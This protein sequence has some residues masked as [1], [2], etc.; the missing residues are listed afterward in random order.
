MD[1]EVLV[2]ES[3]DHLFRHDIGQM[4]SVLT[5]IFGI[6]KLDLVEDALQVALA[7]A[8]NQW[9]F[10]GIPKNPKAWLI[11]V[12]KNHMLDRLRRDN[13]SVDFDGEIKQT[14]E[15][16]SRVD[17]SDKIYFEDE[18]FEDQLQMIFA[19]CHPSIP[20]DSQ[21]ALTLK[22]VGGFSVNEI[23]HAFLAKIDATAKMIT[24]AK[25]RLR[26]HRVRLEIPEPEKI[27][28][29]LNAVLKVLYLMFNE[30][31]MAST[32][33]K[34]TRI[35][36]CNEAIRLAKLLAAHSVTSLPKVNALTA[37]LLFQAS[38]LPA[39]NS[40]DGT[41]LILA[42]QDRTLWD[43]RKI[44]EGLK[45]FRASASGDDLSV[46]HLE[47]EIA[48]YH[49]LSKSFEATD[50]K[51]LVE[52]Y[53]E[54]LKR[55]PSPIVALNKTIAV[56]QAQGAK[57]ALAE[58]NLLSDKSLNTYYPFFITK[59]ELLRKTSNFPEALEAYERAF[60]LTNN[61]AIKKFVRAKITKLSTSALSIANVP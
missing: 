11:Q 41:V 33:E 34:L 56:S 30:G 35:D 36:L 50:W 40:D 59:G 13:K 39:R 22:T 32:G 7:K 26:E 12:A 37:L 61:E 48:S 20:V 60:Q 28:N 53:G 17:F 54:L 47:A 42:E 29:R 44:S 18:I 25:K 16:A 3:V 38:R 52:S 57:E 46:Y 58:L 19:C 5:R 45:Y 55:N 9:T 31:Y 49:V 51:S 21:I 43:K 23:A 1:S 4:V 6:G 14:E 15:Y 24:R 8:L 10:K 27:P 2:N